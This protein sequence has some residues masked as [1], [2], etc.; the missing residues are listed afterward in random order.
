MNNVETQKADIANRSDVRLLVET[1][2][3]HI[4]A[5]EQL[6]PVFALR[7]QD[8]GW[9][10]H[11]QKMTL[12]WSHLLLQEEGYSGHPLREHF[13]LPVS[14][15]HFSRWLHLWRE[16]VNTLFAGPR[17]TDALVKAQNIAAVFQSRLLDPQSAMFVYTQR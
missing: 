8:D 10:P 7:I 13:G 17:A 14:R 15:D 12:F 5:D 11:L 9:E 6:A 4:R 3:G 2:Y 16:S 1:F